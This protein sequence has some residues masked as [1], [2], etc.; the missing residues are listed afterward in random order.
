MPA[1]SAK[2][3]GDSKRENLTSKQYTNLYMQ[4]IDILTNSY[5]DGIKKSIDLTNDIKTTY[6]D[7]KKQHM[8]QLAIRSDSIKVSDDLR[9]A[10]SKYAE[11]QDELKRRRDKQNE[12]E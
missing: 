3:I 1:T 7:L 12:T 5:I 8:I 2:P 11:L 9:E 6:P 10:I 4:Y